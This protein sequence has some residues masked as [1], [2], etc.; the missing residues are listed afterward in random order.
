CQAPIPSARG[1]SLTTPRRNHTMRR[2]IYAVLAGFSAATTVTAQAPPAAEPPQ[3]ARVALIRP[4]SIADRVARADSVVT[5]K[6]TSIEEKTVSVPA[7]PGSKDNVEY[8]VAVVKIDEA[9]Q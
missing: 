3:V 9:I 2:L 6:V 5:G 8:L 1:A 4:S 7:Y